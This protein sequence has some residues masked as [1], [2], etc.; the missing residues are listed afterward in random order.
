MVTPEALA[1]LFP[2]QDDIPA[3]QLLP[4]RFISAAG[5]S[6]A[7]CGP[8]TARASPCCRRSACAA[9]DGK[10]TQVELGSYPGGRRGRDRGGARRAAVAAYDNGRGAWPTMAV[11][12]R[13][14]CMQDFAEADAGAPAARSCS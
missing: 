9:Q 13:I 11:A 6:T 5:S 14:A 8:G 12:E 10:L 3:E 7:S 2:R 4:D 1:Q